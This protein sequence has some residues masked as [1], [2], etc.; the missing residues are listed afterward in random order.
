MA[1]VGGV[2]MSAALTGETAL[3]AIRE[4]ANARWVKVDLDITFPGWN[5]E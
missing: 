1:A 3:A 5:S 2:G 4:T